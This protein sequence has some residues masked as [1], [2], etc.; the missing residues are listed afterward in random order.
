VQ[1]EADEGPC[2]DGA[3]GGASETGWVAQVETSAVRTTVGAGGGAQ[4]KAPTAE[5]A[6]VSPTE[7]FV[8]AEVPHQLLV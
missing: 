5:V 1:P 8:E 6:T 2:R 7:T 3:G 4:V